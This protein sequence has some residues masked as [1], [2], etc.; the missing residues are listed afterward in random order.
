MLVAESLIPDIQALSYNQLPASG[1]E[2][3]GRNVGKQWEQRLR[4][5]SGIS[6]IPVDPVGLKD[7]IEDFVVDALLSAHHSV[8]GSRSEPLNRELLKTTPGSSD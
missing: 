3:L 7:A 8:E 5:C 4:E 1:G 6:G 2:F